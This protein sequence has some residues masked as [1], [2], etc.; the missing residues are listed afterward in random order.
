MAEITY[1][2]TQ[3][4]PQKRREDRVNIYL[5]GIFAFGLNKEVV[6]KHHLH[7]GDELKEAESIGSPFLPG[8]ECGGVEEEAKRERFFREDNQSGHRGFSPRGIVG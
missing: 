6:L 2:I 1:R 3:I 5:N 7:E 8:S 4:E